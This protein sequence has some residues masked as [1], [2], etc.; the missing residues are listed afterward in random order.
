[1]ML[2]LIE[3]V[4]GLGVIPPEWKQRIYSLLLALI[5]AVE[6]FYDVPDEWQEDATLL[7]AA[8]VIAVILSF[9][10]KKIRESRVE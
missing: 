8:T 9:V 3:K 5:A 4:L 10:L 7:K 6:L 2:K 1:M